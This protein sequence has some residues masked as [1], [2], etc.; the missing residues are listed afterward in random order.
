MVDDKAESA[1]EKPG[2]W[3]LFRSQMNDA[4]S[5]TK[6]WA[7]FLT[8]LGLMSFAMVRFFDLLIYGRFAVAPEEVGRD[9]AT[10]IAAG[11][12]M[13]VALVVFA[14]VGAFIFSRLSE[15]ISWVGEKRE[16]PVEALMPKVIVGLG[17]VVAIAAISIL[18]VW[19]SGRNIGECRRESS[20]DRLVYG[21]VTAP[22]LEIIPPVI[23]LSDNVA[24]LGV[25]PTHSVLYDCDQNRIVRL[26]KNQYAIVT[27]SRAPDVSPPATPEE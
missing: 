19:D 7:V 17:A 5:D 6:S 9:Y 11:V 26:P 12:P 14:L 27:D 24:Y 23:G 15:F 16:R 10:S 13:A 20:I 2:A 1:P 4:L 25:G 21:W 18:F 22:V 3:K 8:I